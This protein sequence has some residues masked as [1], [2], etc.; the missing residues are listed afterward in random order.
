M[1]LKD[2]KAIIDLMR[3]NSLSEFELERQDFKI[4]LKRGV[5]GGV[6]PVEEPSVIP[7]AVP[8]AV[9][10]PGLPAAA[11]E[12]CRRRLAVAAGNQISDDR[13]IL[14][15]SFAGVPELCGNRGGSDA[16]NGRLPDRGDEGDERNQSRG[17]RGCD[18]YSRRK[19]QAG[20]VWPANV[21]HPAKL[22]GAMRQ[23]ITHV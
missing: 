12:P 9:A 3:K 17:Q 11:P 21:S 6:V 8:L 20:R 18:S 19:R 22:A 14:P 10:A 4:K 23:V 16:R 7:Y 2:I 1:D 13:H 15:R 5:S